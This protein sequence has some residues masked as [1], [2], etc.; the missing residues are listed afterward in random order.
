MSKGMFSS[1]KD[2]SAEIARQQEELR[3]QRINTGRAAI[4]EQF[5][6]FDES[7]YGGV[8][9]AYKAY[10][11][12]QVKTNYERARRDLALRMPTTGSAYIQK[13]AEMEKDFLGEQSRIAGAAESAAAQRKADVAQSRLSLENQL[14]SGAGID[15]IGSA[16]AAQASQAAQPL[17]FSP[18]A[19]IFSKYANTAANATQAE[20]LGYTPVR[21]LSFGPA[22]GSVRYVGT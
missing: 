5:G 9:D 7:F 2:N 21:G 3:Q 6:K 20:A 22:R 11:D 8:S 14:E 13:I 18:L 15:T 19:D 10:Y 16:A 4:A 1:P 17:Q 12:P